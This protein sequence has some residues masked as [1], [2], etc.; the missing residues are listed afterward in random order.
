VASHK[1]QTTHDD[2]FDGTLSLGVH[3]DGSLAFSD[4][5]AT[6]DQEDVATEIDSRYPNVEY[7]GEADGADASESESAADGIAE[8]PLDPGDHTIG[9]LEA[10]LEQQDYSDA[11]LEALLDAEAAG[12][13]RAGATDAIEESLAN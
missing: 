13:N 3:P 4:G 1:L 6:V 7:V 8:P 10:E 9:E 11:E 5:E 2:E 12:K